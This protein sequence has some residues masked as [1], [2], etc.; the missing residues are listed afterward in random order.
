[1]KLLIL[2][3]SPV[4]CFGQTKSL[5]L[6]E[7]I[8]IG[9]ENRYDFK[10]GQ[11]NTEIAKSRITQAKNAW[12][13]QVGADGSLKY[14]PQLQNSVIPGGVLPG[15]DQPTLLPL[16]VKNQSVFSLNL[17]Q[18]I[19]DA[20]IS[21]RKQLAMNE[22]AMQEEKR[23]EQEI[24]IKLQIS[25]AYLNAQLRQLQKKIA[26]DNAFRNKEYAEIAAGQYKNGALI[27]NYYLRAK[28]D[29]NNA[30]LLL[31]QA[32]QEYNMSITQLRYAINLPD[33]SMLELSDSLDT[34]KD[35][36]AGLIN[37][38]EE[39]TEL[40][41]LQV[42]QAANALH[43]KAYRQDLLPT[44]SVSGNYSQQFL[45]DKFNYGES[46]WWSPFSFLMLQV[47]IPISDHYKNSAHIAEYRQKENQ[48]KLLLQQKTMDIN[49]EMQQAQ[50]AL[51]NALINIK[52]SRDK[53]Q[54]SVIFIA[55][56][57]H[58]QCKDPEERHIF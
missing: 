44:V 15:F 57:I 47:R 20:S 35:I 1:M 3:L 29:E 25:Q 50:T 32:A 51:S 7:A 58:I 14:S 34:E 5:S 48:T 39:R 46:K 13:P 11:Y 22:L 45:S 42:E 12:L 40:K 10:A 27:E 19:F 33:T 36:T 6:N 53:L 18:P 8:H 49:Y 30:A 2:I 23:K 31:K 56:N 9:L 41:Q 16:T 52:S 4:L 24:Q 38:T 37:H 54:R 21:I 43:I 55:K 17:D 26:A 28:L